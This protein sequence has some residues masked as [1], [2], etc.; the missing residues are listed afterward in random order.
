MT[1][2]EN[3]SVFKS[4]AP[5][6][7]VAG[8]EMENAGEES[9]PVGKV[10]AALEFIR[11]AGRVSITLLARKLDLSAEQAEKL[12]SHLEKHEIIGPPVEG[13]KTRE[14]LAD[15]SGEIPEVP[16]LL[17]LMP[18]PVVRNTRPKSI[19][20]ELTPDEI[21]EAATELVKAQ[22]EIAALK[23]ELAEVKKEHKEQVSVIEV[24]ERKFAGMV[25]D[26]V[27]MR[28][29][30]CEVILDYQAE[31]YTVTRLDTGEVV[32]DREMSQDELSR[33]PMDDSAE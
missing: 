17:V 20:V 6:E 13:K 27:E 7:P 23:E 12:L 25:R 32:E 22:D 4:D 18:R 10:R 5:A 8:G 24:R 2:E 15:L 19:A 31:R 30:E 9:Q 21:S 1:T 11:D 29:V 14:I 28:E 3:D 26:K 16:E 33:L